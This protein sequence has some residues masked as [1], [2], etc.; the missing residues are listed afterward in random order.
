M[1]FVL[2]VLALAAPFALAQ[3][4]TRT[5]ATPN[6][7]PLSFDVVSIKPNHSGSNVILD[8]DPPPDGLAVGN[9]PVRLIISKAFGIREDLI[10]GGPA[11]VNTEPYDLTAKVAGEDLAAWKALSK[12][13]RNQMLQ[14]VLAERFHLVAHT[15]SRDLPGY[16]LTIAKNGPLL[17]AAKP[18][19]QTGFGA[20]AGDFKCEAVSVA[21]LAMLLSEHLQ[22]TVLDQTGLTG[23]YTFELKWADL[24]ARQRSGASPGDA[25]EPFSL[26]AL[27]TALEE[28]LGLKLTSTKL[29]TTTLVIDHIERPSDN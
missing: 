19:Q 1:K 10:S 4:P 17:Q 28:T 21:T 8:L 25:S 20:N 11:W 3:T 5:F 24:N 18:E 15:L 29:P 6:T 7:K 13:Q 22:K 2:A 9:M 23:R 26:P 16:T 12:D 14:S 27:P